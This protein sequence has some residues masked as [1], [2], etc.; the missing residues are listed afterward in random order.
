MSTRRQFITLLGGAAVGWPLAAH[1]Q[2]PTMPV[3]GLLSSRSPAVDTSLIALIRQG[4]NETGFVEGQNV[5]L[6][7]RW[8]E[9]RQGPDLL[10]AHLVC[11]ITPHDRFI[12]ELDLPL[13]D[14]V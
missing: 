8:A 11:C 2:Q 5:A 13:A 10:P 12:D 9:G 6:N 4:L 7:Y 14:C 3:I 1:A